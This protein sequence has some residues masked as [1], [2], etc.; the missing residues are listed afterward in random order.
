MNEAN[1][2]SPLTLVGNAADSGAG[3]CIGDSCE[4]PSHPEQALINEAL[5]NDMV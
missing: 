3:V 5:D 2:I 1:V 4:V